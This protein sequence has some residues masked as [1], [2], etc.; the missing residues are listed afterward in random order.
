M[1][2]FSFISLLATMGLTDQ[3]I[4]VLSLVTN[5]VNGTFAES[6]HVSQHIMLPTMSV[7]EGRKKCGK[8]PITLL[9]SKQISLFD[10]Y[11]N[12]T[13]NFFKAQ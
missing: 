4:M 1:L 13:R 6:N 5:F 8:K 7:S 10:L 9:T 11:G 2:L 3:M 12:L